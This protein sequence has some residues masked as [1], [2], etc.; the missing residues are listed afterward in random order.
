V[1]Y[2][3]P[4]SPIRVRRRRQVGFYKKKI[5]IVQMVAKPCFS[6]LQQSIP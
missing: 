6:A 1:G 5:K 4:V 3:E 2:I